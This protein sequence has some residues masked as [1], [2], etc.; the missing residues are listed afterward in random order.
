[1]WGTTLPAAD[2]ED[3]NA[4]SGCSFA[5]LYWR[6]S[7]VPLT[8]YCVALCLAIAFY[9]YGDRVIG[10]LE[11]VAAAKPDPALLSVYQK[12]EIDPLLN[13]VAAAILWRPIS[14]YYAVNRAIDR[15][16]YGL[17]SQL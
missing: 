17:S 3:R 4:G 7:C 1:M 13:I 16:L 9:I 14:T 8:I 12:F 6:S 2:P 10:Y 15:A 11:Q 5:G